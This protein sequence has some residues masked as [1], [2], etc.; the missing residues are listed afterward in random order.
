MSFLYEF[1]QNITRRYFFA[2]GSHLLGGAALASLAGKSLF[3]APG[4]VTQTG[5]VPTS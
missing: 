2:R 3:A 4:E 5:A 1:K